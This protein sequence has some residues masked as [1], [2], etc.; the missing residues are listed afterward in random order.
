MYV[1]DQDKI[2]LVSPVW[3]DLAKFRH[4]GKSL[5]VFGQFLTVC[6]CFG[7]ML[8]LLWQIWDIIGLIFIV[9]NC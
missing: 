9:L 7:K 4:F 6:I 1:F 3:P 5:Q 2:T 8:S